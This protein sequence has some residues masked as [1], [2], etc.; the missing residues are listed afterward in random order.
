MLGLSR[1]FLTLFIATV[2]LHVIGLARADS[3]KHRFFS[4]G[5]QIQETTKFS[6]VFILPPRAP[7]GR[8]RR[9]ILT[10]QDGGIHWEP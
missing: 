4:C 2:A 8:A 3:G 9:D 7:A 6:Q 1:A 10:T 5:E